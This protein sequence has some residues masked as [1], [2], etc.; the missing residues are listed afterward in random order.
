MRER[1]PFSKDLLAELP[2]LKLILTTGMKNRGI[3]IEACKERLV[4]PA[5]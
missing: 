5:S 2:G 3:D 1:T 4:S